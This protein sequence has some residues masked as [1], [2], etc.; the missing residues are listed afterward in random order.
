MGI[1]LKMDAVSPHLN[2]NNHHCSRSPKNLQPVYVHHFHKRERYVANRC[3]HF[4]HFTADKTNQTNSEAR[5]REGTIPTELPPLAGEVSANLWGI[6]WCRVI[7]V[8]DPYG[9][10]LGFIDLS[11]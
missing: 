11:F 6:E 1:S 3:V 9:R 5:V 10:I 7:S 2:H 4:G 8:P